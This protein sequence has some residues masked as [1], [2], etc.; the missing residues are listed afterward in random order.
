[1]LDPVVETVAL[2]SG[3]VID[4]GHVALSGVCRDCSRH[5]PDQRGRTGA[6]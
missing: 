2:R 3:F 5:G 4:P 6:K 1:L